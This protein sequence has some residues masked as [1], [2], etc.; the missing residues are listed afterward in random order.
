LNAKEYLAIYEPD[1]TPGCYRTPDKKGPCVAP[2]PALSPR[3]EEAWGLFVE[4]FSTVVGMGVGMAPNRS[5]AATLA[6]TCGISPTGEFW[7]LFGDLERAW[8]NHANEK[9]PDE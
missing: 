4:S 6:S 2:P 8:V 9:K 3:A 1:A 7:M 5:V